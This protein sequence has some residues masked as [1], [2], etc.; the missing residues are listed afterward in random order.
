[1]LVHRHVSH[2]P[3]KTNI[4]RTILN[5]KNSPEGDFI[6]SPHPTTQNLFLA[7]G[8]SG[9]AYKF[10]P[11]LGDKV[12]DALEGTL[13]PE[14]QRLWAWPAR[15]SADAFEGTEDGSRSGQKGLL[16]MEELARSKTAAPHKRGSKL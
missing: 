11:V 4:Q 3:L 12:V 2:V 9:H 5:Q 15:K 13:D 14:L 1:M 6:V 8:G 10:F 7:T 16:L